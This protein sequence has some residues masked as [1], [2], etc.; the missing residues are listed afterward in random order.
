MSAVA[1]AG[2]AAG[3]PRPG[4]AASLTEAGCGW[5][6]G[7]APQAPN[8][9]GVRH[10]VSCVNAGLFLKLPHV[11]FIPDSFVAEPVGDLWTHRQK[12]PEELTQCR[13]GVDRTGSLRCSCFHR[14]G[15]TSE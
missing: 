5:V 7:L 2:L 14:P 8:L 10:R 3:E 1:H 12:L 6:A 13:D 4:P 15:R 9:G 11:L